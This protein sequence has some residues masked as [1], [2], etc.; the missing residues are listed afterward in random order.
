MCVY[1]LASGTYMCI[2]MIYNV[3]MKACKTFEFLV[4]L[5]LLSSVQIK[6]CVETPWLL[7]VIEFH[8]FL[9]LKLVLKAKEILN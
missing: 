2:Y 5:I 3:Y 4:Y 6:K 1:V 8:D 9:A 7:F